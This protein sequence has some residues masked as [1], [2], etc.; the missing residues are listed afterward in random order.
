MARDAGKAHLCVINDAE[1]KWKTTHSARDYLLAA[2]VPVA[3]TIITHR[4]AYLAAMSSGKTG[5]EIE[6]RDTKC[7][8]E[9]DAL[10]LEI[11]HALKTKRTRRG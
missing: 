4:A 7:G 10:W 5:P 2:G 9:I 1:P 6:R 8:E 3:D 11:K